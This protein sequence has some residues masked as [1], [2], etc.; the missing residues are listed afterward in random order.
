MDASRFKPNQM[1]RW[2]CAAVKSKMVKILEDIPQKKRLIP[3]PVLGRKYSIFGTGLSLI[4]GS[5]NLFSCK[6]GVIMP[7][8]E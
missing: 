7:K 8:R 1:E 3:E 6:M 4:S 2:N 5:F